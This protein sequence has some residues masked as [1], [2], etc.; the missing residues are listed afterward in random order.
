MTLDGVAELQAPRQPELSLFT[1]PMR[2]DQDT[3]LCGGQE[4][5]LRYGTKT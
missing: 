2:E 3:L 5:L 1:R 4:T